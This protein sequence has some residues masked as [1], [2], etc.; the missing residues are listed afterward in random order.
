[1]FLSEFVLAVRRDK[2]IS[3]KGEW[4]FCRNE[5]GFALFYFFDHPHLGPETVLL[6]SAS[7]YITAQL[8]LEL[9]HACGISWYSKRQQ[10]TRITG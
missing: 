10:P 3:R 8:E 1:M 4:A 2:S 7:V 5:G 6:A 9:G